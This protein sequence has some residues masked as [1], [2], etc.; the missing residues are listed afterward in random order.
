[1]RVEKNHKL[2][3]LLIRLGL[4][5]TVRIKLLD[6]HGYGDQNPFLEVSSFMR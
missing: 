2:E 6:S 1:M 3:E 5:L 4:E